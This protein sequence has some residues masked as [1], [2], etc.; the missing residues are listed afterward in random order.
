MPGAIK[1][2]VK[3]A[4]GLAA[5]DVSVFRN[6][7]KKAGLRRPDLRTVILIREN[8]IEIA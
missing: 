7:C 1:L 8:G 5:N 2:P 3:L 4:A 6:H